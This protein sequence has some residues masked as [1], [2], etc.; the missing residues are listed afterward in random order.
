MFLSHVLCPDG[1]RAL[2]LRQGSEA[3][4]VRGGDD[5]AGLCHRA[6]E[7][8]VP[9]EDLLLRRGL[10][11]PVDVAGLVAQGRVLCPLPAD[12]VVLLPA[13][14]GEEEV[15]PVLPP[16]TGLGVPLSG[17][18]EGGAA[19]VLLVGRDGVPRPLGWVQTQ[20]VSDGARAR[21]LSCGPELCLAL[22]E[23]PGIGQA[24]L[25]SDTARIAEFPIPGAEGDQTLPELPPHPP[26]TV[27]LHR[28]ARW[29]LRPRRDHEG[30]TVETRIAGLGL[31]LRNP[32]GG[33]ADR[34]DVRRQA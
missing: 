10:G 5:L 29:L 25:F 2:A 1:R 19:L 30:A 20:G 15:V 14:P 4:L 33:V 26:G 16:G 18:L 22:P 34:A 24:R 28:A 32:L 27:I 23:G 17:A 3:A 11:D 21:W 13:G 9:L 6:V 31:P 12:P 8:G 7:E